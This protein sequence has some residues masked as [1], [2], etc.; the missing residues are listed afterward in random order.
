MLVGYLQNTPFLVRRNTAIHCMFISLSFS[1]QQDY[2]VIDMHDKRVN[3]S[4]NIRVI[5]ARK[6]RVNGK[7]KPPT[8]VSRIA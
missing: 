7:K 8:E 2:K 3:D 5:D 1:A 4:L 6:S